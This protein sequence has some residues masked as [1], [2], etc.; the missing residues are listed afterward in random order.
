MSKTLMVCEFFDIRALNLFRISDFVLST[1]S[2]KSCAKRS[3]N[4]S[5]DVR[6]QKS[7][8]SRIHRFLTS[9]VCSLTSH[10]L[11]GSGY[12]GLCKWKGTI[13]P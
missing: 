3:G 11:F 2:L 9:D 1:L 12:A 10:D 6:G 5:E 7:E 13:Y 4:V 8:V